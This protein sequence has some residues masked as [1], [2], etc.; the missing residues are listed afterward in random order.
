MCLKLVAALLLLL[1]T[2]ACAQQALFLSDPP[3]AQVL[4]DG[5]VVGHTPCRYAYR[6]DTGL[7]HQ[8]TIR[9]SGFEPIHHAIA[10]D[11]TD[12]HSRDQ[13]LAAGLV[14]SPLWLGTLFTKKL[15]ATY[16]FA[17]RKAAPTMTAQAAPAVPRGQL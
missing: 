12:S 16:E 4:V 3:G 9:K 11:Q 13:W 2:S 1:F 8:V 15:Q 10:S 17:L 7:T 6:N 5:Q 14:W